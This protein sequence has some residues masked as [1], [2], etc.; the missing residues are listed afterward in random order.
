M[1]RPEAIAIRRVLLVLPS[2]LYAILGPRDPRSPTTKATV[3]G[4][5]DS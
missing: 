4:R 5:R 3:Q 1:D 2:P